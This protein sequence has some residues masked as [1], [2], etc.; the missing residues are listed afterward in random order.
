MKY[1]HDVSRNDRRVSASSKD[2]TITDHERWSTKNNKH[3]RNRGARINPCA[4][5]LV[6]SP[7]LIEIT[8]MFFV[9]LRKRIC[10]HGYRSPKKGGKPGCMCIASDFANIATDLYAQDAIYALHI[11]IHPI[12]RCSRRVRLYFLQRRSNEGMPAE[13]TGEL[14][15]PSHSYVP[16]I[17]QII[18]FCCFQYRFRTGSMLTWKWLLRLMM[19]ERRARKWCSIMVGSRAACTSELVCTCWCWSRRKKETMFSVSPRE[20]DHPCTNHLAQA[21]TSYLHTPHWEPQ[22]AW[23]RQEPA[24]ECLPDTGTTAGHMA[25]SSL[26]A[27]GTVLQSTGSVPGSQITTRLWWH[28]VSFWGSK[29]RKYFGTILELFWNYSG[30]ILEWNK[31][32]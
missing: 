29:C 1:F 9:D 12:S 8:Q 31:N 19:T 14:I 30:T 6:P 10:P 7:P 16:P 32:N 25:N 23:R 15:I 24:H 18:K 13:P 3:S 26:I 4:H 28:S 17:L 20:S 27:N 2:T 11:P 5:K 21:A 22:R